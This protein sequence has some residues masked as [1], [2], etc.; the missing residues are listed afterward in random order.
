MACRDALAKVMYGRLFDW[1]VK[2]INLSSKTTSR[3]FKFIGV[4]DI[5]GFETFEVDDS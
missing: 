2:Q 5:Y 1:T 4:L 3:I